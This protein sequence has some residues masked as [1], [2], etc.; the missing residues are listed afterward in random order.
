VS[1]ISQHAVANLGWTD[2]KLINPLFVDDTLYAESVVTDLRP[3]SSHLEAGI[4][5]CFTRGL[6]QHGD[7]VL[8]YRRSVLV[9]RRGQDDPEGHFPQPKSSIAA[10]AF[11]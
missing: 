3:S 9:Y 10:D 6:N 2:I 8:S 5:G 1:D 4:I 7:P 11:S